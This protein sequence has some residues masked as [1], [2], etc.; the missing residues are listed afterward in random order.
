MIAA[1]E[2]TPAVPDPLPTCAMPATDDI[3][4]EGFGFFRDTWFIGRVLLMEAQSTVQSEAEVIDWLDEVAASP[5]DFELLTSAIENGTT[6]SLPDPLHARA[7]AGGIEK[8]LAD[9]EDFAPLD[10]LE[11]GVAGLTH[12]LSTIRCLTAAS[13][14]WHAG[15]KSW[16]DCP[17]VFFAAPAWRTEILAELISLRGC[18]LGQDRGLLTV[19]GRSIRDTHRLAG[20]IL[21]ERGRFRRK[22]SSSR[23]RRP[24]AL[25]D[26]QI[27]LF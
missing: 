22:P 21:A 8:Y 16:S 13:C 1:S 19:Y 26:H 10:G 25:P 24:S 9:P 6:D 27:D 12:A 11:I 4:E 3:G 7:V 14:R 23:S 20:C 17:V 5:S 15:S 2:V 18:G